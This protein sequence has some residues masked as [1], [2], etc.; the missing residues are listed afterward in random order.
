MMNSRL[1]F[2]LTSMLFMLAGCQ[3]VQ[4]TGGGAV[5]VER[6]QRMMIS[7]AQINAAAEQSYAQTLREAQG[8]GVLTLCPP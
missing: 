5:G 2:A 8:K 6:Q 3:T 7:S 1:I 4:T